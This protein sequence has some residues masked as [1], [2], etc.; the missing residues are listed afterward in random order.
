MFIMDKKCSRDW[1]LKA[2]NNF[3]VHVRNLCAPF[4][5]PFLLVYFLVY[6]FSIS[7]TSINL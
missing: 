6:F 4:L 1:S 5:S 7:G 2:P 3:S